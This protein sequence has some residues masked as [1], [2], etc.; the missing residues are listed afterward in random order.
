MTAPTPFDSAARWAEL[1][2]RGTYR[3]PL[4]HHLDLPARRSLNPLLLHRR[5]TDA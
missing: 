1:S 4:G 2:P 5:D 3:Y